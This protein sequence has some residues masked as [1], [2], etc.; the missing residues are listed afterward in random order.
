MPCFLNT[1]SALYHIE[2]ANA[3]I[4]N[5]IVSTTLNFIKIPLNQVT[6]L[7][8]DEEKY[9]NLYTYMS[10]SDNWKFALT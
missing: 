8:L 9:F 3:Q 10:D 7:I 1:F 5:L 2:M 4:A 6:K